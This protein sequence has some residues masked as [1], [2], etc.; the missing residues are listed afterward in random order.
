MLDRLQAE[1]ILREELNEALA[2]HDDAKLEFW[3]VAADIPSG[4]PA[5]DGTA[6][7]QNAARKRNDAMKH[8]L[9]AT[10]RFNDFIVHGTI[11]ED[12]KR[13]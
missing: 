13:N 2:I 9:S 1:K 10:V 6:R 3:R 11:P 4:L 12:L 8:L 7:I 5:P